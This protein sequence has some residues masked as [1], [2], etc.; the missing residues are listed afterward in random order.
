MWQRLICCHNI[1][2]NIPYLNFKCVSNKKEDSRH[3]MFFS[4]HLNSQCSPHWSQLS[5]I[6]TLFFFFSNVLMQRCSHVN[7]PLM[8]QLQG[9]DS[10][11]SSRPVLPAAFSLLCGNGPSLL[12][13]DH[14]GISGWFT[15]LIRPCQTF[16]GMLPAHNWQ[17]RGGML[18]NQRASFPRRAHTVEVLRKH[19]SHSLKE[20][21][22]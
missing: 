16:I 18:L 2:K 5:R 1:V 4:S 3:V 7:P 11:S 6:V 14:D 12:A 19:L 17:P 10:D 22:C 20:L 9:C 13:Q 15:E 8:R 21:I